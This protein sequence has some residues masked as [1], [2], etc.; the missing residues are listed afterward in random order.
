MKIL[1][2]LLTL[3]LSLPAAVSVV[4]VRT[5][6]GD[7]AGTLAGL[8]SAVNDAASSASTDPIVIDVEAGA[9]YS[10]GSTCWLNLPAQTNATKL[11]VIRS[12]RIGEL[13]ENT[14][15][16]AA[17]AAKLFKVENACT[18][19]Q[20]VI[21]A[22]PGTAGAVPSH[23]VIQG[24][25]AHY[26]G[27]GRSVGGAFNVGYNP[28]T[29]AKAAQHS[30][31]PHT[32]TFDRCWGHGNDSATWI[33]ASSTHANQNGAR[34]DGKN[35]T[36]KNS[37]ISD[38]N[39]DTVDH[40]QGESRGIAGSN[41]PGP[42][43]VFNNYIDGAIGSI[44]G[45]EEPWTG[46][47]VFTGGW[48]YGNEYS[49]DPVIWH[50]EDW[51]TSSSLK[52]DEPCV[53]N[54]FF[55]Q[56]VSPSNKWKCVSGAWA[57]SS[58]T[59]L[60]RGWTKNAWEC[61]SC[62]MVDVEG[63][64]IHDVAAVG[65]QSQV[66]AAFLIN[67]VDAFFNAPYARP[68]HINIRYNRAVRTGAGVQISW[69]GSPVFKTTNN[70]TA[71]HNLFEAF[72]STAVC[73]TE[74]TASR[75]FGGGTQVQ[76]SGV[77]ANLRIAKNTFLYLN[78]FG[79]GGI[80]L[81]DGDGVQPVNVYLR[82]NLLGWG[83]AGQSPL[84][85]F[86]EDCANFAAL[87][88]GAAYWDNFALVDTNTRGSSAF[89][90]AYASGSCPANKQRIATYADVGFVSYNSGT[91]GDYRICTGSGTPHAS[92]SGVSP[93]A[94]AASDGGPLGADAEQVGRFTA[95]AVAGTYDPKLFEMK[96]TAMSANQIRYT[97]YEAT[98]ACTVTTTRLSNGDV[99]TNSDDSGFGGSLLRYITPTIP[100]AGEYEVRITCKDFGGT[101]K[102]WKAA[103]FKV[104][105]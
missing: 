68:E 101:V 29:T 95:G 51:D 97:P 48:F 23:Y 9:T 24:C 81:G 54:S 79:G 105:S 71:E 1:I 7:Y 25:E 6:G 92:C 19:S 61:K 32:I 17:D 72:C 78:T 50:W 38:N 74:G 28:S 73:P 103:R 45:G 64:Y 104:R 55:Q 96:I 56:K 8:Q 18:S 2:G 98:G 36:I 80:R 57:S 33:M 82:D 53:S 3:A 40:G 52:T 75:P 83:G 77:G 21:V 44:L 100:A 39:M 16:T 37:R 88:A 69:A 13:P 99:T 89:T 15:V 60:N 22:A 27:E 26:S 35:I 47:L 5:T 31:F 86:S 76:V 66:G 67:N 87:F 41:A 63:N 12:S 43:Y 30:Q 91:G 10:D 62:R 102:G 14:R 58:D 84:N 4:R 46:G 94:T 59:R 34:V 93:V 49:R 11:I 20:G 90:T 70:I 85:A 42:L 65:D